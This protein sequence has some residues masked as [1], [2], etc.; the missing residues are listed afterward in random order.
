MA[1]DVKVMP[2]DYDYNARGVVEVLQNVR[3]LFMTRAGTCPLDRELGIDLSL[4]DDPMPTARAKLQV[5]MIQKLKR[6]E[7]RARISKFGVDSRVLDGHLLLT[8]AIQV[9]IGEGWL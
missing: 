3:T 8:V 4:I 9:N 5:E 7:P 1:Y 6:Y 2:F